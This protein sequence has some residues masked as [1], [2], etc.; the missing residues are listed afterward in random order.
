MLRSSMIF[1]GYWY[2]FIQSLNQW[3]ASAKHRSEK[4]LGC[5]AN[6]ASYRFKK[7]LAVLHGSPRKSS[8]CVHRQNTWFGV[9]SEGCVVLMLLCALVLTRVRA[10]KRLGVKSLRTHAR[11]RR[12]L[13]SGYFGWRWP[14]QGE[15]QV[16]KHSSWS[17]NRAEQGLLL[18]FW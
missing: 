7:I 5:A 13:F 8:S 11:I 10:V 17:G 2:N 1:D 4:H 6:K 18:A 12:T 3:I 14:R 16:W 15:G 9:Y